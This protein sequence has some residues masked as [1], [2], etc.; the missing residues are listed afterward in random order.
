M[1]DVGVKRIGPKGYLSL[2]Q[3]ME[4]LPEVLR[5]LE[6][7]LGSIIVKPVAGREGRAPE[8]FLLQA[9]QEGRAAF[10]MSPTLVMH[11]GTTHQGDQESYTP[12]VNAILRN[13]AEL[14]AGF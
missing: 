1:A 7:R 3:R 13:G 9:R 8:L 10:R 6:G 4:R 5:A 12:M 14:P 11:V 2:I